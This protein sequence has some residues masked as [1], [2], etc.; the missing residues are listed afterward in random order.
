MA[1][2]NF[3]KVAAD[4][5]DGVTVRAR[6]GFAAPRAVVWR[7][8]TEAA[9][10]RRWMR[11]PPGWSMPVCEMDVRVEGT[12]QWRWR[13]DETGNEFGF[14]GEYLEVEA[15]GRLVYTEVF[16]PGGDGVDGLGSSVVDIDLSEEEG[17]TLM[18]MLIR[19][20]DS[21]ARDAAVGSGLVHGMEMSYSILDDVLREDG[22]ASESGTP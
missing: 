17:R 19:Y 8:L 13:V 18:T 14:H 5:P 12:F 3:E 4:Q 11:G 9:T 16:D 1:D 22:N 15:P 6:R 7:A 2:M 21:E 20:P 10:V